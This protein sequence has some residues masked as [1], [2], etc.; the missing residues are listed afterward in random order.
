MAVEM[1][2]PQTS[3][4]VLPTRLAAVALMLC[5]YIVLPF[6]SLSKAADLESWQTEAVQRIY[7]G[8]VPSSPDELRWMEV[9]QQNLVKRLSPTIVNIA[10]GESQGSG[11]IISP[12]G[13]VLTAAH[14]AVKPNLG[15][16]ITLHDGRELAGRTLGMNKSIDAGLV[17]IVDRPDA[18]ESI[19]WPFAEMGN[20]SQLSNGAWCLAFGHPGG[21]QIG[22]R[23]VVR[24]GRV[25]S[26]NH[27]SL[28]TD[29]ALVGGDSGGP[30]FDMR[31]QVI[32]IHSRIGADITKNLHVPVNTYRA[33][34][35]RLAQGESW[36]NL[37]QLVGPPMIGVLGVQEV[38][39]AEVEKVMPGLPAER[40]GIQ[41]GDV[42]VRFNK[43]Q[44]KD[45]PALRRLVGQSEPGEE[46]RVEVLRG[47]RRV[48]LTIII[49]TS[50]G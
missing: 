31:V 8:G 41:V 38:E 44:V 1:F 3:R 33:T 49:G 7:A 5:T 27:R 25:L 42:I 37:L 40:A 14:V 36:G 6:A 30:L 15:C 45:F 2:Y 28:Q 32:G 10:V 50:A 21:Y 12:D 29:C 46:V 47:N 34:W 35:D 26:I 20:V 39:R 43:Q 24:F 11:V 23:P 48:Q 9:H 16:R 19:R 4:T 17:K 22:R 18:D 13:Y